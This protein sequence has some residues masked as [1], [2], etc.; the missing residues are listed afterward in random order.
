MSMVFVLWNSFE[1]I[2]SILFPIVKSKVLWYSLLAIYL[3]DKTTNTSHCVHTGLE[4]KINFKI[5]HKGNTTLIITVFAL[6]NLG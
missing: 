2:R 1:H 4:M 5:T 3:K 6:K